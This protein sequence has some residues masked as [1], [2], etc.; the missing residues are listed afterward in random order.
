MVTPTEEKGN[1]TYGEL[2]CRL[3][4]YQNFLEF[5][6]CCYP[7]TKKLVIGKRCVRLYTNNMKLKGTKVLNFTYRV[8]KKDFNGYYN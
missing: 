2:T 6:W 1:V 7:I 4:L 5:S 3:A 8:L